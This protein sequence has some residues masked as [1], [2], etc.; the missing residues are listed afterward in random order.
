MPGITFIPGPGDRGESAFER[1][2]KTLG[3]TALLLQSVQRNN[4]ELQLAKKDLAIRELE[5]QALGMRIAKEQRLEER[6]GILEPQIRA[7]ALDRLIAEQTRA[8]T[9]QQFGFS[10][11]QLANRSAELGV[12]GQEFDVNMFTPKK[13]E[14]LSLGIEKEKEELNVFRRADADRLKAGKL[15][16]SLFLSSQPTRI[17]ALKDPRVHEQLLEM[18]G[19]EAAKMLLD[20]EVEHEKVA[21]DL[22]AVKARR[23]QLEDWYSNMF[24]QGAI[25]VNRG[26]EAGA[27]AAGAFADSLPDSPQKTALQNAIKAIQAIPKEEKETKGDPKEKIFL[28]SYDPSASIPLKAEWYRQYSGVAAPSSKDKI[29]SAFGL[30]SGA[31]SDE[32][33]ARQ[34]DALAQRLGAKAPETGQRRF[35]NKEAAAAAGLKSGDIYFDEQIGKLVRVK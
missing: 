17:A 21:V 5:T 30:P 29:N 19:P 9:E 34:A 12:L 18:Y 26:T 20:L 28:N 8:Q 22:E 7:T 1:A 32:E 3:Q 31:V 25:G 13:F 10:N 6:E 14:A 15:L 16:A 24:R 23:S 27:A 4:V 33:A 35:A 2:V 11:A